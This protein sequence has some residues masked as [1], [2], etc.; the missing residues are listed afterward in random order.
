VLGVL[1]P[2]PCYP[3]VH[4]HNESVDAYGKSR[5]HPTTTFSSSS[6]GNKM[7]RPYPP[8]LNHPPQV[9]APQIFHLLKPPTLPDPP[10][11][12]VSGLLRGGESVRDLQALAPAILPRI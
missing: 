1:L 9:R 6:T 8:H 3:Q 2:S 12:H 7:S 5:V 11:C 4:Q 10:S